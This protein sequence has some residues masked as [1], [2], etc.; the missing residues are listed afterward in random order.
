[1]ENYSDKFSRIRST[2]DDMKEDLDV[3]KKVWI[4]IIYSDE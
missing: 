4:N 3:I 1:M 2:L